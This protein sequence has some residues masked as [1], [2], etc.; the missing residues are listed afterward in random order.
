[1]L[2]VSQPLP[3]ACL[4]FL[5]SDWWKA[6]SELARQNVPPGAKVF[7]NCCGGGIQCP[8]RGEEA[9]G[10]ARTPASLEITGRGQ[11]AYAECCK[12]PG[13]SLH[14]AGRGYKN[15][16]GCKPQLLKGLTVFKSIPRFPFDH[17][18]LAGYPKI[19][20]QFAHKR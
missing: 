5:L 13:S 12:N 15:D 9:K 10:I 3:L 7:V 14:V 11:R 4:V 18:S 1:M 16:R 19:Q 8:S 2:I 17:N 20:E 6:W